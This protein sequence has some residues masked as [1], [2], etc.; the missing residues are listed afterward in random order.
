M[1]FKLRLFSLRTSE[2]EPAFLALPRPEW[3]ADEGTGTEQT[4][5]QTK[6][7]DDILARCIFKCRLAEWQQEIAEGFSVRFDDEA[8][9]SSDLDEL[10]EVVSFLSYFDPESDFGSDHVWWTARV[11]KQLKLALVPPHQLVEF[12][13]AVHRTKLLEVLLANCSFGADARKVSG[14]V[15]FIEESSVQKPWLLALK[16]Y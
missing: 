7:C 1:T 15:K 2:F 12:V 9:V 8:G 6:H 3:A 13:D 11:R 16:W 4:T 14:L 5:D 10:N